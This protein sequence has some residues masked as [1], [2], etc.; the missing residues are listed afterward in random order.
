MA[1]SGCDNCGCCGLGSGRRESRDI[2]FLLPQAWLFC[3]IYL[4]LY[5]CS[6]PAGCVDAWAAAV[7]VDPLDV[8][9]VDA[10]TA[11]MSWGRRVGAQRRLRPTWPNT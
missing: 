3:Y 10:W 7:G 4:N 2:A 1:V 6:L 9:G 8:V 11:G 5:R